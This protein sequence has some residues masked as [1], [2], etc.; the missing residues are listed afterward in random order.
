MPVSQELMTR[1]YVTPGIITLETIMAHRCNT[2]SFI[3]RNNMPPDIV[4]PRNK[5]PGKS[6]LGMRPQLR[7]MNDSIDLRSIYVT[8]RICN[9]MCDTFGKVNQNGGGRW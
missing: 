1:G 8:A 2:W 3:S 7:S 5:N 9:A 6:S 4:I